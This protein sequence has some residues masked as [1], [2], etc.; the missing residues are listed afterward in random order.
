M[1]HWRNWWARACNNTSWFNASRK[2][3]R[4]RTNKVNCIEFIKNHRDLIFHRPSSKIQQ[5]RTKCVAQEAAE[6]RRDQIQKFQKALEDS[7]ASGHKEPN[8]NKDQ[9]NEEAEENNEDDD[10]KMMDKMKKKLMKGLMMFRSGVG[11][12][13]KDSNSR[14]LPPGNRITKSEHAHFLKMKAKMVKKEKSSV[15]LAWYFCF[16]TKIPFASILSV[17]FACF[18]RSLIEKCMMQCSSYCVHCTMMS[19]NLNLSQLMAKQCQTCPL[20]TTSPVPS[21]DEEFSSGVADVLNA[22]SS[23]DEMDGPN[24]LLNLSDFKVGAIWNNWISCES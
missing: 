7:A 23:D 3:R 12:R 19:P 18:N 14:K 6:K 1:W 5:D 21:D 2:G 8:D 20:S 10:N 22:T 17:L 15:R 24:Q 11:K 9:E 13:D 16:C 4:A